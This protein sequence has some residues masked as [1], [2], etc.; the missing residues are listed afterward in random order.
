MESTFKFEKKNNKH[1]LFDSRYNINLLLTSIHDYVTLHYLNKS[2]RCIEIL[3]SLMLIKV[4]TQSDTAFQSL[5]HDKESSTNGRSRLF[6]VSR[7]W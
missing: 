3:V 2:C 1:L 7:R 5:F 4:I 6:E